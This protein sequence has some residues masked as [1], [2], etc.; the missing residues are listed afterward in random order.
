MLG[1]FVMSLPDWIK[2]GEFPKV[3][4]VKDR[5]FRV[6]F[7]YRPSN[8]T[9]SKVSIAGTFNGWNTERDSLQG[10]DDDGYYHG[11]LLLEKGHYEYKFVVDGSQWTH[12]PEN[13][14]RTGPYTNSVLRVP[15]KSIK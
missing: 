4:H 14:D 5:Q 7:R 6:L 3:Q 9:V 15:P 1:S 12:D 10:P 11:T 13:R 2:P 8:K